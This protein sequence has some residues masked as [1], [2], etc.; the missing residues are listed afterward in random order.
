MVVIIKK[1]KNAKT[2]R[3]I[4]CDDK[5]TG[6][7]LRIVLNNGMGALLAGEL[8]AK[9]DTSSLTIKLQQDDPL[10]VI[11]NLKKKDLNPINPCGAC[12]EWLRKISEKEP[13]ECNG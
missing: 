5:D 3:S 2:S 13:T 9:N 6:L 12:M 4:F 7:R 8:W 11:E 10:S 1:K